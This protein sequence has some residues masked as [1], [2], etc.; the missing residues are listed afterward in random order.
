MKRYSWLTALVAVLVVVGL[1]FGAVGV[2][3]ADG[4]GGRGGAVGS[5]WGGMM[6]GPGY[7]SQEHAPEVRSA[8]PE[9]GEVEPT[10]RYTGVWG[11][12]QQAWDTMMGGWNQ[13]F[14][15]MFGGMMGNGW[16]GGGMTGSW[17]WRSGGT[18][19]STEDVERIA[20]EYVTSYGNPDLEVAEIMEFDNQFYVQA[21]EESTG[22]YAFEFLIDR[23][24][25][26]ASPEPG[27]NMMWNSKYGH[28]GGSGWG[29]MMG[30]WSGATGSGTDG[31]DMPITPERAIQLAQ[32][33]LERYQPGLEAADEAD[34]FY[35]YYTI[36]TVRDGET[37]GMLSVNGYTGQVWV[38]SWH[39]QYLGMVG[40]DEH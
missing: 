34:A 24:S 40:G 32:E 15:G 1:T 16:F 25:G 38:H 17:G 30:S 35:G 21:R 13:F 8:A 5:N 3:L 2:V 19:I 14:G 36:H 29:G 6:S 23:Y 10:R 20:A 12:M 11:Y 22:R 27:P 7:G 4:P 9:R 39:G 26:N 33:Y 18:P 31:A 28:M 37:V